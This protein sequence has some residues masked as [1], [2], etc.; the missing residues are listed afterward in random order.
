MPCDWTK[1]KVSSD[2]ENVYDQLFLSSFS[3][4]QVTTVFAYGSLLWN[5]GFKAVRSQRAVVQGFKRRFWN[6]S[7]DHRG[8]FENP[9]LVVYAV[10]TCDPSDYIEGLMLDIPPNIF[11][12]VIE[13]LDL[14]EKC[15]YIRKLA[16]AIEPDTGVSLGL[17]FIYCAC[18]SDSILDVF[19][20]PKNGLD[21]TQEELEGIARTISTAE[22][23]SG[24]NI[25]YLMRLRAALAELGSVDIHVDSWDRLVWAVETRKVFER[26]RIDT[27][28]Q[29]ATDVQAAGGRFDGFFSSAHGNTDNTSR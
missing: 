6:L 3:N 12:E 16:R 17:V 19:M 8:T 15:G 25:D 26:R 11:R 14:R 7:F 1:A 13:Q 4:R 29:M 5:P 21:N 18:D 9:G 2:A 27:G 28:I 24:K 23:A 10:E 20:R 22:G